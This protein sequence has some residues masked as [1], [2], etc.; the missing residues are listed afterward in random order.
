MTSAWRIVAYTKREGGGTLMQEFFLVAIPD[1]LA[2]LAAL[3]VRRRDLETAKIEIVGEAQ[4]WMID[5]LSVEEGQVLGIVA[6]S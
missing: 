3:R 6:L 2:A 1:K 5:W 4:Q